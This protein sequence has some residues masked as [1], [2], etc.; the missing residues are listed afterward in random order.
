VNRVGTE[1]E[2]TFYGG[3]FVSNPMG[4][5][6]QSLTDE[7]GILI[8]EVDLKEIDSA[9]NLLQFMRDRRPDTY[10]LLLRKE[11]FRTPSNV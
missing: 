11:A 3:S 1:K 7:E 9:R 8:Q 10:E 5:I 2:M 4:E 6:L